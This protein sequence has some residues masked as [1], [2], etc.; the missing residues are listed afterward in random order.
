MHRSVWVR[1][2]TATAVALAVLYIAWAAAYLLLP[3]GLL[4]GRLPAQGIPF[5][6][7]SA[8]I[9]A[10]QIGLFNLVVG[11]GLVGGCNLVQA[12]RLPMGFVVIWVWMALYGALLGT[13]SFGKPLPPGDSVPHLSVLWERSGLREFLAYLLVASATAHIAQWRQP[14][15]RSAERIRTWQDIRLG[16]QEW[17]ALSLAPALIFWSAWVEARLWLTGPT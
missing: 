14:S 12:K 5:N 17:A 10:L 3:P 9:L 11:C 16:W 7:S 8:L 4:R 2:L 6:E 15:L 13:N 1:F